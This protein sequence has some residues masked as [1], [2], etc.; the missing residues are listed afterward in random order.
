MLI[1]QSW[2]SS[3][4]KGKGLVRTAKLDRIDI[5]ILSALQ[6][7]GNITNVKLAEQVGLSSSPCLQRVKRLEK[8]GYIRNYSAVL[9]LAKL[10]DSVVVFT[11][12]TLVDHR[13]EEFI[14]FE[15]EIAKHQ[16]LVDCYL[17]SGGYDYLLK[18]V[19]RG[20]SQY[21]KIMEDLLDQ[22][23]GIDKYFSYIAIKPV[24]EKHAVPVR[25]LVDPD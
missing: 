14:K 8:A 24:V 9:N 22:N 25:N 7:Q 5:N 15:R 1:R 16:N 20:V 3:S 2:L 10:T 17:L 4:D 6:E 23:I 18:F 19:V 12:V 21:Q 11:E 13:R